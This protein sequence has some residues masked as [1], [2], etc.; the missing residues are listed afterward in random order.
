MKT[1]RRNKMRRRCF[2]GGSFKKHKNT[3]TPPPRWIATVSAAEDIFSSKERKGRKEI[4][5]VNGAPVII[6]RKVREV[7][8][9]LKKLHE[10]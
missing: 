5:G 2:W 3:S 7:R 6:S 8:K 10:F 4:E 1:R 9:V